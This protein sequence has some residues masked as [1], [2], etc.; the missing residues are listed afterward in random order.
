MVQR[1]LERNGKGVSADPPVAGKGGL[2]QRIIRMMTSKLGARIDH[3]ASHRGTRIVID[4][5]ARRG[6]PESPPGPSA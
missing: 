2:G 1:H 3:D 5:P 4:I 6:E